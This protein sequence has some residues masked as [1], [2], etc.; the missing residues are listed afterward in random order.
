M[1]IVIGPVG[2]LRIE[3]TNDA[4]PAPAVRRPGMGL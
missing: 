4:L 2:A 1:S 3:N